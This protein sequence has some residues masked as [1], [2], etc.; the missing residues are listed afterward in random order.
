MSNVQSQSNS[1]HPVH[2]I[3]NRS[4]TSRSEQQIRSIPP[5][6][7]N[8]NNNNNS[9]NNI[10][11]NTQRQPLNNN[12]NNNNNINRNN[13]NLYP[14]YADQPDI[15]RSSQ[16]DEYYKKLFEDQCFEMLTRI[17]GP[18]F[19]MNRQSESKLL[20]NTIYYL[21]TTMIGSQTLGEEYCN[22]RKIK[23]KTFSIPSIP[24]RIKLYFFHLLA[25][26]L[27]KKSLPKLFQRHPKLYI[28]KEIFPKFERLHLALFY[29]N[30]SYFEFS[31]RLSDIRYIFNRKID[32]KR[33]KYDILGLLIII[34]LLLSTFMYLKENS[35]FL[36]QQQ[37]DGGGNGDGEEDNQDLNKDIKIEQV[38]SVINN[39]NQDQNNNQ[40]EEEEQKCTLC[41]EV[42]THTT[43]TICGHLFCW[44][45]ITEWCNNKEQCPVCR[46][47][48]SIRTCVPLYN[49]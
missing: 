16:K 33:P 12:N 48:I 22:L 23:D 5:T 11:N 7:N 19:I 47:P 42:R 24:D 10:N 27:I 30:G 37:K 32:Q 49:Y 38:D 21:L 15:L 2:N 43:A 35:F 31:K 29:F 28:L 34:Q 8:N 41:L 6:N 9:I 3:V 14:S 46:C 1:H 26:Y 4:P 17:T 18:R 20:A 44:H 13:S 45:C 36:K 40:E 39:N 25:P